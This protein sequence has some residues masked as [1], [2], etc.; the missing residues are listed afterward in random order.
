MWPWH[1]PSFSTKCLDIEFS[2]LSFVS[3]I[4]S[5]LLCNLCMCFS[6]MLHKNEPSFGVSF[7]S[8][9]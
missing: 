9:P 6:Y 4:S 1:L 3:N 8:S 2:F 5:L 7:F